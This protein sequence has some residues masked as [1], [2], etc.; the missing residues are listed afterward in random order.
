MKVAKINVEICVLI[1]ASWYLVKEHVLI[2]SQEL[3][4][5]NSRRGKKYKGNMA[6]EGVIQV[7]SQ[8]EKVF[9]QTYTDYW[10]SKHSSQS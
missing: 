9:P 7:K 8:H 3:H 5:S 1:L 4:V 6:G 2:D 10:K